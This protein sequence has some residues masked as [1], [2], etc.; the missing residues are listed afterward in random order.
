MNRAADY[1]RRLADLVARSAATDEAAAAALDE[2]TSAGL[3][4]AEAMDATAAAME[5]Q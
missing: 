4:L 1:G 2:L 3:E 5:A